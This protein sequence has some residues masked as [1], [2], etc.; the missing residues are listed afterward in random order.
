MI[1]LAIVAILIAIIL[2]ALGAWVLFC[3]LNAYLWRESIAGSIMIAI[4]VGSIILTAKY[5][6]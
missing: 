5:L 6:L 4:G 2:I 3:A 1:L